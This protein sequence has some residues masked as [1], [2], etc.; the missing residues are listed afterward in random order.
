MIDHIA[1]IKINGKKYNVHKKALAKNSKY[2]EAIFE[3]DC[4]ETIELPDLGIKNENIWT[5]FFAITKQNYIDNILKN[6]YD[7]ISL[8]KL[9][10]YFCVDI[11]DKL[12]DKF[13]KNINDLFEDGNY[14]KSL[15]VALFLHNK[16]NNIFK[17][18]NINNNFLDMIKYAKHI[19]HADDFFQLV[20]S[21]EIEYLFNVFEYNNYM[22]YDKSIPKFMCDQNKF[23]E[24]YDDTV[25]ENIKTFKNNMS[26]LTFQI[27]DEFKWNNVVV[28]GGAVFHCLSK[29]L[30]KFET[31]TDI[32]LFIYGNKE[33]RITKFKSLLLFFNNHHKNVLFN[34]NNNVVTIA[35]QG[36]HRNFQIILTSWENK[37]DLLNNFDFGYIQ[38][39]YDGAHVYGT[40]NFIKSMKTQITTINNNN[41]ININRI[42]KTYKKGF[43]FNCTDKLNIIKMFSYDDLVSNNK[44]LL[45]RYMNK[46]FYFD[47]YEGKRTMLIMKYLLMGK[48]VSNNVS[49]IISHIDFD[50]KFFISDYANQI[51]ISQ[52]YNIKHLDD[53]QILQQSK[54]RIILNL[55]QFLIKNAYIFAVGQQS[56]TNYIT[57]TININTCSSD[58]INFLQQ[59]EKVLRK[60]FTN[61]CEYINSQT[62][63]DKITKLPH[64]NKNYK[65]HYLIMKMRTMKNTVI[66]DKNNLT[67]DNILP[68]YL[69][70]ITINM[71]TIYDIMHNHKTLL[72]HISKIIIKEP[73][74]VY[75]KLFVKKHQLSLYDMDA[76]NCIDFSTNSD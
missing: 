76:E 46:Y 40:S 49:E 12:F 18:T 15:I 61:F 53:I 72:R 42:V 54:K 60:K 36:I 1:C 64:F 67:L 69:C 11:F 48:F 56:D 74:Y 19:L 21:F 68:G 4:D 27:L 26:K 16:N 41:N 57:L 50:K 14:N 45:D 5:T 3:D 6:K 62:K 47:V 20:N 30:H 58:T 34:V 9:A 33:D 43:S 28:A 38:C 32:D 8:C 70:D 73:S 65:T 71:N 52:G 10:T 59:Y 25:V 31:N 7:Y 22:K 44:E 13:D 23:Y 17:N 37:Y 75:N 55:G 63:I 39:L 51:D 35:I 24:K 29:K 66:V 2:F